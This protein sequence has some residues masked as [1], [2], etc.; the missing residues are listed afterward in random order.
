MSSRRKLLAWILAALTACALLVSVLLWEHRYARTRW[1]SFLV[2]DPHTGAQVFQE[3][4]CARCHAPGEAG[5]RSAPDLGFQQSPHSSLN[6]LV[7]AMWNHA[8]G[9]W[10][11]MRAENRSYPD[12]DY[13]EMAHLFAYLYTIQYLEEPGDARQGRRLFASKG[14]M[15]CHALRGVGGQMGPDLS[16][17]TGVDTPIV[18]TQKMWNHAPAMEVAMQQLGLSWSKFEGREMSDLLAYVREVSGGSRREFELLPASPDRGEKLF[19]SKSCIVCHSV[20]Q[21]G[22]TI[23]PSLG[24]K[25]D[26]PLS[27][28]QFA[29][30]MWNHSPQ[31]WRA[32]KARTIARPSFTGREMADLIAFIESVRYFEAGGSPQV[33][34]MVF[35]GR[36]CANCHGLHAEGTA[37]GPPIRGRGGAFTSVTLATELWRHG[38]KMYQRT[39]ALGLAWPTLVESDVGDLVAFLNTPPG[40]IRAQSQSRPAEEKK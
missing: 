6:Q 19:Q 25:R 11:R 12:L 34:E 21:E 39:R 28:T 4:G 17:V 38:P 24:A 32:M 13:E 14:C 35:R 1:A 8:P 18:W 23:G 30:L 22:G 29:G 36:G 40:V 7:S 16:A 9:M 33:G 5:E 3:K 26:L 10:E 37:S 27:I 20:K 2:G 31:M 15:R